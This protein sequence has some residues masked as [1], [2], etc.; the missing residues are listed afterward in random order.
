MLRE[1]D[2][3]TGICW[4]YPAAQKQEAALAARGFSKIQN[5]I[6]RFDHSLILRRREVGDIHVVVVPER[7]QNVVA[8]VVAAEELATVERIRARLAQQGWWN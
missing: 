7:W 5:K 6:V 2:V 8:T 3:D 1:R 4:I